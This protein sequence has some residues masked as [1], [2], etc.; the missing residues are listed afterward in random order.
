MLFDPIP[1]IDHVQLELRHLLLEELPV[2]VVQLRP[3]RLCEDQGAHLEFPHFH[4]LVGQ[5]V[6]GLIAEEGEERVGL[7]DLDQGLSLAFLVMRPDEVEILRVKDG[8]LCGYIRDA[9]RFYFVTDAIVDALASN[10]IALLI[11]S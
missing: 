10:D 7:K 2:A 5:E 9:P 3:L 1:L 6:D 11:L 8:D 4:E